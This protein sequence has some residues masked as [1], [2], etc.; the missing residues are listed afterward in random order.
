M[1]IYTK[2]K[3]III[4]Y[5]SKKMEIRGKPNRIFVATLII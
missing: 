1:L 5:L 3:K 4:K 2:E